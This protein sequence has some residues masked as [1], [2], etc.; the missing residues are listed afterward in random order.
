MMMMLLGAVIAAV[1]TTIALVGGAMFK[2]GWGDRGKTAMLAPPAPVEPTTT[3]PAELAEPS[4]GRPKSSA[5]GPAPNAVPA[6]VIPVDPVVEQLRIQNERQ[7]ARET[8]EAQRLEIAR[9]QSLAAMLAREW[10]GVEGDGIPTT[11]REIYDMATPYINER[12]T[13]RGEGWQMTPE[14]R[15]QLG[16]P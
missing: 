12:L 10:V 2:E 15:R 9:R 13:A 11:D 3:T 8:A 1:G 7:A 4:T 14:T 16:L 5:V 6:P